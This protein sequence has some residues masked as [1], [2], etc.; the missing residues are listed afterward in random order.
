M[1]AQLHKNMHYEVY[2][3]NATGKTSAAQACDSGGIVGYRQPNGTQNK[4][5]DGTQQRATTIAVSGNDNVV[6]QE[7]FTDAVNGFEQ[8]QAAGNS[9]LGE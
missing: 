8:G 4:L 7:H 6:H 3:S 2:Q 5:V 1:S 9:L